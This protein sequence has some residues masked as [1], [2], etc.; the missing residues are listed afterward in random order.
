MTDPSPDTQSPPAP[1]HL[2]LRALL[3]LAALF[4]AFDGISGFPF[5]FE[6]MSAIPGS[7][8]SGAIIKLHIATH[9]VLAL[10]ALVLAAMG[11][12]RLAIIALG[13]VV[14]IT[15]LNYMPSVLLHGMD[16]RGAG[17][18]ET[19]AQVIAFP[20]LAVCAITLAARDRRLALA[21]GL[22]IAPTLF[23]VIG[24]IMF[25]IDIALHGF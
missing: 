13:A 18:F 15:W 9:P 7:V 14:L 5:L 17:A 6:D 1:H 3:V 20:L 4:E 12:V 10:A 8:L 22:V 21:T 16:F 11:R 25:A 24:L 23:N 2:G 19:P